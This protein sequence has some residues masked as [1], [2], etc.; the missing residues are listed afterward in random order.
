[1]GQVYFGR[2]YLGKRYGSVIVARQNHHKDACP[3]C[4]GMWRLGVEVDALGTVATKGKDDERQ[5]RNH[6]WQAQ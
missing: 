6:E 4:G 5:A 2:F 3:L 1:M